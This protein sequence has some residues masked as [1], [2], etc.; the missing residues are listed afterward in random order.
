MGLTPPPQSKSMWRFFQPPFSRD[1]YVIN[2]W[3]LNIESYCELYNSYLHCEDSHMELARP[4]GALVE[5][6]LRPQPTSRCDVRDKCLLIVRLDCL[7]CRRERA[8]A[9]PVISLSPVSS[10][11][12]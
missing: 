11:I 2:E 3:P 1:P 10:L 9:A 8:R 7:V 4:V 12:M 6:K 5:G